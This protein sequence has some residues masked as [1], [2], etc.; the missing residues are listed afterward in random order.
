VAKMAIHEREPIINEAQRP[1][2]GIQAND[3]LSLYLRDMWADH[4]L[5]RRLTKREENEM[6]A[7]IRLGEWVSQYISSQNG[8]LSEESKEHLSAAVRKGQEVRD[9]FI[10]INTRLVVHVVKK[11]R[12]FREFYRL[13]SQEC[14]QEGNLALAMAVDHYVPGYCRGTFAN[15]AGPAIRRAIFR[16]PARECGAMC[17]AINVPQELGRVMNRYSRQNGNGNHFRLPLE[18]EEVLVDY[19]VKATGWRRNKAQAAIDSRKEP[20]SLSLGTE[21][22]ERDEEGAWGADPGVPV[23]PLA[24]ARIA[25]QK[26]KKLIADTLNEREQEIILLRY[27]KGMTLEEVGERFGFTREWIRQIEAIA[28]KKLKAKLRNRNGNNG[29]GQKPVSTPEVDQADNV[30][31][32]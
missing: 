4:D 15:Y 5:D 16:L 12:W 32:S 26:M 7:T 8:N 14:I 29:H 18:E 20:L 9:L 23:E 25:D 19:V 28:K 30:D 27:W 31:N 21:E 1:T 10:R 13:P 24:F 3:S 6:I 2:P 11:L 17:V 22:G